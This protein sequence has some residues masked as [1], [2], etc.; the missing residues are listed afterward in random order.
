MRRADNLRRFNNAKPLVPNILLMT[1]GAGGAGLDIAGANHLIIGEPASVGR[2]Y[3]GA[4]YL[5][6]YLGNEI[7]G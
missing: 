5:G 2:G 4:S 6:R 7:L 3:G 1:I